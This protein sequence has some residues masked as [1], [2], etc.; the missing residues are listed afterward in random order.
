MKS[1]ATEKL[2][3]NKRKI[4]KPTTINR[5]I[6]LTKNQS[7]EDRSKTKK[8]LKKNLFARDSTKQQND[9][10]ISQNAFDTVSLKPLMELWKKTS[11]VDDKS[12]NS[13]GLAALVRNKLAKNSPSP[14]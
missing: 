13:Q 6:D 7:E 4:I 2:N 9:E 1:L 12:D 10:R 5:H 3:E 14:K 8:A 11:K